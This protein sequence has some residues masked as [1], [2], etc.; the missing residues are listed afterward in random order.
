M[1]SRIFLIWLGLFTL[2]VINPAALASQDKNAVA[3]HLSAIAKI[4]TNQARI[5]DV[6]LSFD[7]DKGVEYGIVV[8]KNT[9]QLFLYAYDGTVNDR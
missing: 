2:L 9:Q 7:V 8:E 1:K 4:Q 6:F 3:K 5:P